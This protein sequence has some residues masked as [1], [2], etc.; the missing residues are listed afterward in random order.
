M[1][2]RLLAV[3]LFFVLSPMMLCAQIT[4]VRCKW[5]KVNPAAEVQLDSTTVLPS[6]ISITGGGDSLR[7]LYDAN[8]GKAKWSGNTTADSV[9]VCFRILSYDLASRH[10]KRSL[11][12]YDTLGYYRDDPYYNRQFQGRK[13][14]LF[15]SPGINKTGT[16]SRGISV[17]NNQSVFVNS[18]LNL[19]L[20]GKL[21]EDISIIA[22]ISDQNIPFQPDGNTQQL[23]QFDKVFVQLRGKKVRLTAGDIL[24]Q[25]KKSYFLKYYR[26]VQGGFLEYDNRLDSTAKGKSYTSVGAAVSKGKFNSQQFGPG[27]GADTLIE[28]V[29]GPYRLRGP[30]N[31]RFIIILANSEAVYLNGTLLK[32]GFDYDYVIDYNQAEIT[33]T[34][35]VVITK[36]SRMR[37]DFEFSDRNYSRT[38]LQASNTQEYKKGFFYFDYFSEKDNPNNPLAVTLSEQDKQYL[39]TIGN[40]LDSAFVTGVDSVGY[41]ANTVLYKKVNT[42]V[43][44]YVYSTSPDSAFFQVGFSQV[45]AGTGHYRL[46]TS[47]VNGRIYQYIGPDSADYE[48]IILVPTPKLLRMAVVGGGIKITPKDKVT[49]EVAFSKNDLNLYSTIGNNETDGWSTKVGYENAGRRVIK[50]YN[51]VLSTN[52]EYNQARFS[53]VDRFRS[54]DFERNWNENVNIKADNTIIDGSTGLFKNEQNKMI[55]KITRRDKGTD[56]N[57][58]Q[59]E[60]TVNKSFGRYQFVSNG[61][62][63]KNNRAFQKSDWYRVSVSQYYKTKYFAPGVE[64]SK[65]YNAIRDSIGNIASSL[66][67][68]DQLRAYLKSN[69]TLKVKFAADYA[70]RVDNEVYQGHFAPN[71]IGQTL[72]AS[73]GGT[74]KKNHEIN[75]LMTYRNLNNSIG[76]TPLPNEENVTGRIDWNTSMFKRHIR[77][78]I[79]MT[80]STGRELKQQY[81]FQAVAS[82][83]GNY[84][85]S[86]ANNDGVQQLSEFV[87]KKLN[88]PTE[89]IKVFLPTDQYIKAYSNTYNHRL[90]ITA[91]RTWKT[92]KS[93]LKRITAK[94]SNLSLWTV[95][96]KIKSEN[97]AD[98][99]LPFNQNISDSNLLSIQQTIRSTFFYNRSNPV[100]GVEGSILMNNSKTFLNQGFE[101]KNQQEWNLVA[102][103]N[104]SSYASIKFT[105]AEGLKST[106]SDFLS[107]KNYEINYWQMN[108][109]LSFQPKNTLRLSLLGGCTFK[110]NVFEAGSNEKVNLYNGGFEM[111]FNKL[112]QRNVTSTIKYIRIDADF[113]DTPLGSPLGYEMLEALLPGNNFTW[114]ISWQEKL[115]NGLQFSFS[116]EGRKS[117]GSKAVHIGRMQLSALF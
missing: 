72:Q 58:Y 22:S 40:N 27:Q 45:A 8:T 47:A 55:Y 30:N 42:P 60:L 66:M 95:N 38:T 41:S 16:I 68:Y 59:Q 91:P 90:D 7:L 25:S 96:K 84:V 115:L 3:L 4:N 63:A 98:R 28:G 34:P 15:S 77:S 12:Q 83:L 56:V 23:Q 86:D 14:E 101:K 9:L 75:V 103:Y 111:K 43:V 71:S 109:E 19:Q 79:T 64:Y 106:F 80:T 2:A 76:P 69:D 24:L 18:V 114:N 21:T 73:G 13:E 50:D 26:N 113:H 48:P 104:V 110:K 29:Q 81:I 35:R 5:I 20:E 32:R 11:K 33:F 37:V 100:Y 17:G 53:A 89:Y 97:F 67:N 88:A 78:E 36:Y 6:S 54:P 102:R 87:E 1:I 107:T 61:F 105:G 116:Y 85:W 51:W 49:A 112:S 62:M 99:F 31:E 65:E 57:G 70:Y 74:L 108:P 46:S 10:Y 52:V 94:L 92:S 44:H 39:S 117:E 93:Q 82:G